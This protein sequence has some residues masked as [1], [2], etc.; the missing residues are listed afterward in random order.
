MESSGVIRKI[1]GV[2]GGLQLRRAVFAGAFNGDETND[3]EKED[4]DSYN[5]AK[6]NYIHSNQKFIILLHT[7]Y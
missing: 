6:C 2:F 3:T 1:K 7:N 4:N 5:D